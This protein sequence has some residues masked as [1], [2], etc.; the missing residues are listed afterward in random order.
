MSMAL[1]MAKEALENG[2][3]PVGCVV[4]RDGEVIARERNRRAELNDPTAHAEILALRRAA[5]VVGDWRL[6]GCDIYVT[7]EPCPMCAGAIAMA[8]AGRLFFGA[9][10]E[11]YGCAG[12]V[13][14]ITEDPAFAHYCPAYG[15]IMRDEAREL[16]DGFF[17]VLRNRGG[18][19]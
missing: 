17:G 12:S 19:S 3:V 15:G 1:D 8:R 10:D 13:Y 7:L 9:D 2:E 4:V 18:L 14:R 6:D 16:L 11:K 5:Q